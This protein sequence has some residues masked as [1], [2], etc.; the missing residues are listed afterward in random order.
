[1]VEVDPPCAGARRQRLSP[2]PPTQCRRSAYDVTEMTSHQVDVTSQAGGDSWRRRQRR[3]SV[4]GGSGRRRAEG[5]RWHTSEVRQV[6]KVSCSAST[7][8]GESEFTG[9]LHA[10][11]WGTSDIGK[12]ELHFDY[13]GN[14]RY[15]GR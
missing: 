10:L 2:S 14:A 5:A 15:V 12:T 7:N 6:S 9:G 11:L 4:C 13:P 1:M 8:S 3:Q